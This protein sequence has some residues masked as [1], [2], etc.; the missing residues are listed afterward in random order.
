MDILI[1]LIKKI[2]AQGRYF[3][4]LLSPKLISGDDYFKKIFGYTNQNYLVHDIPKNKLP[5]IFASDA[6]YESGVFDF[7]SKIEG[8]EMLKIFSGR[9]NLK[10][11]CKEI[12]SII[13]D[14]RGKKSLE[15]PDELP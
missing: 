9:E 14:E 10:K 12:I 15:K 5:F 2:N 13:R 11:H 3:K 1:I 8:R 6:E 4:E 7:V